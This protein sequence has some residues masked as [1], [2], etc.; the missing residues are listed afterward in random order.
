MQSVASRV[1]AFFNSVQD[2]V[3]LQK[4]IRDDPNFGCP[5]RQGIST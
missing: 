3:E 4:A 2:P 5:L 1:L